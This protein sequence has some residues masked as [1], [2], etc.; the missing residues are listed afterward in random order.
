VLLGRSAPSAEAEQMLRTLGARFI[1]ADLADRD[2]VVQALAEIAH[3]MPPLRACSTSPV[4][5]TMRC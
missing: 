2:D 1:R 3:A 5:S 4:R